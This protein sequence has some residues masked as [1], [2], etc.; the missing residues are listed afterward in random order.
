MDGIGNCIGGV[1]NL[2]HIRIL[3][4][5]LSQGHEYV[6]V[7]LDLRTLKEVQR[8]PGFYMTVKDPNGPS[9]ILGLMNTEPEVALLCLIPF[10]NKIIALFSMSNTTLGDDLRAHD[11]ASFAV[12][13]SGKN[14][15]FAA[16]YNVKSGD[17]YRGVFAL[18]FDGDI[19]TLKSQSKFFG[20]PDQKT[21]MIGRLDW[22]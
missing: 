9:S 7:F 10:S 22:V 11:Q 5:Q 12:D 8:I 2:A 4:Y 6:L 1:I 20:Q 19:A 18:E 13:D 3:W 14:V 16:S 21:T 15:W 17:L